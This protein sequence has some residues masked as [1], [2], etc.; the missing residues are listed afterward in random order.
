MEQLIIKARNGDKKALSKLLRK[1]ESPVYQ[2]ALSMLVYPSDAEDATQEILIKVITNLSGFRQE[3]S[4]KTWVYKISV[5]HLLNIK[6][7]RADKLNISF[8]SWE[9][10]IY[11][12][13]CE[14]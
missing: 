12:S 14:V 8:Q 11:H 1:V 7:K 2:L 13:K 10:Y 6:R 9:E 5:N 3:S 4:F